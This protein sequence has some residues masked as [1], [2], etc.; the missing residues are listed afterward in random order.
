MQTFFRLL[1]NIQKKMK[2]SLSGKGA[3]KSLP[4]GACRVCAT[5][6][7]ADDPH[8]LCWEHIGQFHTC[9]KCMTL[10]PFGEFSS[11]QDYLAAVWDKEESNAATGTAPV[12]KISSTA[13]EE[14]GAK[15]GSRGND[16]SAAEESQHGGSRFD[17]DG[18]EDG[19]LTEVAEHSLL[20]EAIPEEKGEEG[21]IQPMFFQKLVEMEETRTLQHAQHQ[22]DMKDMRDECSK[23]IAGS[24]KKVQSLLSSLFSGF[25]QKRDAS[26]ARSRSSDDIELQEI[27]MSR[28]RSGR[29]DERTGVDRSPPALSPHRSESRLQSGKEMDG[30]VSVRT[31][32]LGSPRSRDGDGEELDYEEDEFCLMEEEKDDFSSR[33]DRIQGRKESPSRVSK[34][35]EKDPVVVQVMCCHENKGRGEKKKDDD[36]DDDDFDHSSIPLRDIVKS[37]LQ[38]DKY[39]SSMCDEACL[40]LKATGP[41]ISAAAVDWPKTCLNPKVLSKSL[42]EEGMWAQIVMADEE[43]YKTATVPGVKDQAKSG[44]RFPRIHIAEK[45]VEA[46][47]RCVKDTLGHSSSSSQA[48]SATVADI[49][50]NYQFID[51]DFKRV[52][53][54]PEVDTYVKQFCLQ[55]HRQEPKID[56]QSLAFKTQ[57]ATKLQHRIL[58]FIRTALQVAS[59]SPEASG[60]G[61]ILPM[62][63]T[64]M[65]KATE[66]LRKVTGR[67]HGASLRRVRTQVLNS[68]GL[69][70]SDKEALA[71]VSCLPAKSLFASRVPGCTGAQDDNAQ[72]AKAKE[73]AARMDRAKRRPNDNYNYQGSKRPRYDRN[74]QRQSE[75]SGRGSGRFNNAYNNYNSRRGGNQGS[76]SDRGR[77]TGRQQYGSFRGN[78]GNRWNRSDQSRGQ[79]GRGRGNSK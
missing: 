72:T 59:K 35:K 3:K 71:K 12:I 53:M 27:P 29:N 39:V 38:E 28:S 10:A 64:A 6:L 76:S 61:S 16:R 45:E 21:D 14:T 51:E 78:S 8:S 41:D 30:D 4:K 18:V 58:T 19:E 70:S 66:D 24:F 56:K 77:Q 63:F 23:E 62:I 65:E 46:W 75:G 48:P 79:S 7:R 60:E 49:N 36:D 15:T 31:D 34:P 2:K 5:K 37:C 32:M 44:M 11:Y 43:L 22:Q 26:E 67:L 74:S 68:S 20:L 52:G 55:Q 25:H 13:F 9:A 33:L 47:K 69:S 57:Q 1:E 17:H 73:E 40:D 50:R 54:M 42:F